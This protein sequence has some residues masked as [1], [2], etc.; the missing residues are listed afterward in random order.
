MFSIS[1]AGECLACA[2]FHCARGFDHLIKS[3][4]LTGNFR[5]GGNAGPFFFDSGGEGNRIFTDED[6]LGI[7]TR[8]FIRLNR[9]IGRPVDDERW[10]Q[11]GHFRELIDD[12]ATHETR[13]DD[14][15]T[16]RLALV[17]KSLKL[18]K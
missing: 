17:L 7:K 2:E 3:S 15:D 18:T 9:A 11:P 1:N 10:M 8:Q 4:N 16:N 5:G 12:P 13:A 14:A 6:V